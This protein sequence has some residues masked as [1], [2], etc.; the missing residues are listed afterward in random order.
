LPGDRALVCPRCL[1]EFPRTALTYR[2]SAGATVATPDIRARPTPLDVTVSVLRG[3]PDLLERRNTRRLAEYQAQGVR[4]TCP[5]GHT[6]PRTILDLPT[7]VVALVGETS[8]GKSVYLATL[9]HELV[10]REVWAPLGLTFRL[11]D[12]CRA[13]FAEEFGRTVDE[14]QVP[15]A[16]EGNPDV[17]T[18]REPYILVVRIGGY[19]IANLLLFDVAGHQLDTL[20]NQASSSPHLLVADAA[21][22][23]VP[24]AAIPRL[25]QRHRPDQYQSARR[26]TAMLHDAISL[27]SSKKAS[28]AGR[29]GAIVVSKSDDLPEGALGLADLA[30]EPDY[31]DLDLPDLV[32][33]IE[34]DARY[35]RA[36]LEYQDVG[37]LVQA[38]EDYFEH[39]S[40]HLVSCVQGS[41]RDGR[42]VGGLQPS[43]VTDPVLFVLKALGVLDRER[44]WWWRVRRAAR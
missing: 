10:T 2:T 24:P 16:T 9:V 3:D 31:A 29:A 4:P 14:G 39:C 43:R 8:S 40:Y 7:Y 32:E 38:V 30:D 19:E 25:A 22:F 35:V 37:N 21:L 1:H 36:F 11:D 26:T 44:A 13:R 42:F 12:S 28:G 23:F 18:A 41:P 33:T 27:M 20:Q 5:Q 6:L 34:S 17:L 15:V